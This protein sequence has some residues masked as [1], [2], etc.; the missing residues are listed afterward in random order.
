MELSLLCEVKVL[1]LIVDKNEKITLYSSETN[2][3]NFINS[4]LMKHSLTRDVIFNYDVN[5]C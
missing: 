4:Y 5:I 1:M 2:I 3:K